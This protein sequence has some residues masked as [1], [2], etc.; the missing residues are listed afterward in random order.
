[1][2]LVMPKKQWNMLLIAGILFH[3]SIGFSMGLISFGFA[4]I[5]ALLLYL[6]PLEQEFSFGFLRS[7]FGTR[8][9]SFTKE[10]ASS[11]PVL[12]EDGGSNAV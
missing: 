6:R 11:A 2:A 12:V 8:E 7:L 3:I 5:A 10:K 1:M 4:M 9:A